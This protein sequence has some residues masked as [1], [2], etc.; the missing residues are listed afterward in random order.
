MAFKNLGN[1]C[2]INAALQCLMHLDRMNAVMDLAVIPSDT[3]ERLLFNEYTDLRKLLSRNCIIS[4]NRFVKMIRDIAAYTKN[5]QFTT[6]AQNDVSEFM[7]FVVEGLHTAMRRP[8]PAVMA[9]MFGAFF[10]KEYSDLVPLMYGMQVSK[11]GE[12]VTQEPFFMLELPIPS[13][14]ASLEDCLN[15]YLS[16]EDVTYEGKTVPKTTSFLY[17][18]P[19]LVVTLKRFNERGLKNPTHIAL[20]ETLTL[21]DTAYE[22]TAVCN[23]QGGLNGGHYTACLKKKVWWSVDDD[24]VTP[25]TNP[26]KNAYCCIY[27]KMDTKI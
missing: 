15:S 4:P 6:S 17:L 2:F 7:R 10:S 9:P 5:H 23:H 11:I 21:L 18:P 12:S 8:M 16:P 19:I 14:E 1:T 22:L 27:V 13:H 25:C 24:V 3:P 20:P 26:T